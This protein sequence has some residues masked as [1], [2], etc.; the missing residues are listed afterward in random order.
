M[1][2]I[3]G[4][5]WRVF[6]DYN[7]GWLLECVVFSRMLH[8]SRTSNSSFLL[9]HVWVPV[10]AREEA[11]ERGNT[12]Y[13]QGNNDQTAYI[14]ESKICVFWK[15]W[16]N[17]T[18]NI[19]CT[20]SY[21]IFIY[22]FYFISVSIWKWVWKKSASGNLNFPSEVCGRSNEQRL[23]GSRRVGRLTASCWM[24]ADLCSLLSS[25]CSD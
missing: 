22:L 9:W 16:N 3:H 2:E 13:R 7:L 6:A 5:F 25:I 23:G 21:S 15:F 8:V 18:N 11:V 12:L 10:S 4:E 17:T 1:V 19:M 24:E 14:N 20:Q